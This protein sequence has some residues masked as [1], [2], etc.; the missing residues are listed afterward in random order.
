[1]AE[2]LRISVVIATYNREKYIGKALMGLLNQ[3]L[4][5][6][7]FEVLVI[8]NNCSDASMQVVADFQK[9]HPEMRV[10]TMLETR[11][12]LSY[13]RNRGVEESKASIVTY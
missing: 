3:D 2:P 5:L 8:D 4:A 7:A 10:R 1:M 11:Q 9:A 13:G 6:S 12:G